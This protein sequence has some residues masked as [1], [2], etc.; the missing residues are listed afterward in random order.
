MKVVFACFSVLLAG[1]HAF[2]EMPRE[3]AGRSSVPLTYVMEYAGDVVGNPDFLRSIQEAPPNFLHI[4]HGVPLNSIFGPAEDYSGWK[5]KLVGAETILE[6]RRELR[7]FVDAVHDA[8]VD[9]VFPY[10]NPSIL[11]GNHETGEGFWAFYDHWD[12]YLSLGIG[13]K[14]E[15]AP[16]RWMQ[17]AR[18]TFAPWE[19]EPD[20]P[21]W[22]YEP[23][24]NE[25]AWRRYQ[26]ACVRLIAESGYDG[27]FVDDCIMECEHDLC[28]GRF[29]DFLQ[30]RYAYAQQDHVW[31]NDLSLK[32]A[33]QG[34]RLRNAESYLFWQESIADFVKDIKREA[35]EVNPKFFAVPNWGAVSRVRGA[36]GRARSG[37]S[38]GVWGEA[39]PYLMFEEAHPSGYFSPDD[40][41]GYLLQY[42]YALS[43]GVRPVIISYGGGRRY[44][45]LGHAEAAAGGG[46]AFIQ[47]GTDFPE[48]R[49]K[50]R[51][52][53][54]S[55]PELFEGLRLAAPVGL[56]LDYEEVRYGND[57]HL[58]EA[59]VAARAL[60]NLH[61]PFAV[62]PKDNL[63][64]GQLARFPI[65]LLPEVRH[66]SNRQVEKINAF[67][68]RG[69][70]ILAS[71]NLG[72]RNL[73]DAPR[74]ESWRK[75]LGDAL[76]HVDTLQE[77]APEREFAVID[78]LDILE[79]KDFIARLRAIVEDAPIS[80]EDNA[81]AQTLNRLAGK[82]L[83]VANARDTRTTVYQRL[84]G[85]EGLITVHAVR[86]AASIW[87][88]EDTDIAPATLKLRVPIP[89]G[90]RLTESVVLAPEKE[91]VIPEIA[92]RENIMECELPSFEFYSLLSLR[93]EKAA[94]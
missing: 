14:P 7:V 71:G 94:S 80:P 63:S 44:V 62:M 68:R 91:P 58:R 24:V 22:R 83:S 43:L 37:K 67:T 87:K 92:R 4:G 31:E 23:C 5:P 70:K 82:N 12:E 8:G 30:K 78:A 93:L 10:V 50:W 64:T 48:V 61:I 1:L 88:G 6:R 60:H 56:V 90:W 84:E 11:G 81:F 89:P 16:E 65:L 57:A 32:V 49:K 3:G 66:L 53:Y 9:K 27:V 54:E 34:Q 18:R 76:V 55:Y 75:R 86:Y 33:P 69:G 21:L 35:H 46:G 42:K 15:R 74:E 17:R 52:F 36:S 38:V 47:P 85:S 29:P 39:S 45:E 72:A 79:E 77:L 2:S 13:P 59:F 40:V 51:A 73:L 41:F 20:Y 25:P 19:P 26:A 28:Q